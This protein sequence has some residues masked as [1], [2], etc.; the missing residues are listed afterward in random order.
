MYNTDM[1]QHLLKNWLPLAIASTII[2]LTLYATVQQNYRQTANDPQ[3]QLAEDGANVLANGL[4]PATLVGN[5]HVDMAKSLAPFVIIYDDSGK[6]LASSGF[7][8][9]QVPVLPVGVFEY[10]RVNTND[11]ITWQPASTTR[12]AAVVKYFSGNPSK[13]TGFIVAGRSIR[14]IEGREN[15][16][17]LMIAAAWIGLLVLTLIVSL[18]TGL[19][20]RKASEILL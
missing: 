11:R 4:A 6:L 8:N 20:E 10:T 18:Y 9:G 14:E 12:I 15:Q 3:I 2:M 5:V 7:L 17:E 13:N 19:A 16:L 1:T